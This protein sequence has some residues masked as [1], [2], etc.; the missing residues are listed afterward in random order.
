MRHWEVGDEGV[1]DGREESRIQNSLGR[2]LT[3]YG[4]RWEKGVGDGRQCGGRCPERVPHVHPLINGRSF[5]F[6]LVDLS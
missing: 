1:G 5:N 2:K 6:Y 3:L 4:G